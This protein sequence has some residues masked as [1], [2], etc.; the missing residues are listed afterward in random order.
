MI[1][2][3]N[4]LSIEHLKLFFKEILIIV[5][6]YIKGYKIVTYGLIDYFSHVFFY[7]YRMYGIRAV[8]SPTRVF[9]HAM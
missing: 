8:T 6:D 5:I 4:S 9:T 7:Y 3:F 2:L 1:T